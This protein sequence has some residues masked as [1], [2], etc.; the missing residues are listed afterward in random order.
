[1]AEEST[2]LNKQELDIL[3]DNIQ[4]AKDEVRGKFEDIHRRLETLESEINHELDV[5]FDHYER[6]I[7]RR[8]RNISQ[9]DIAR[10]RLYSSLQHND[11]NEALDKLLKAVDS[12]KKTFV[13]EVID[14]PNVLVTWDE[15]YLEETL[16]KL[17]KI[18]ELKYSKEFLKTT[19]LWHQSKR[20]NG[21]DDLNYPRGIAYDVK[22][23]NLYVADCLNDRIQVY[24]EKGNVIDSICKNT[25]KLPR[26]IC[27]TENFLFVTSD[28]HQLNKIN[29]KT[30]EV[31]EKEKFQYLLSGIDSFREKYIYACDLMDLQIIVMRISNLSV[32]RKFT[33]K[34][35]KN[36]DTQTRDI[37]VEATA[38]YVLFHK[39]QFPLQSFTHEG[40][41]IR[42]IVTETMVLDAKYFCLDA[43][44]NF[45][46]I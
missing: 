21:E 43:S 4:N 29:K 41:L 37:R 2:K 35:T 10:S 16:Q 32:K 34:A 12:E 3:R 8:S 31:L 19:S 30:G 45:F 1:M 36:S 26:R 42:H 5:I 24:D 27:I 9:L 14:V 18:N 22:A 17:C 25:V 11:L 46:D 23:H 40:V 20:G 38:I 13:E 15:I 39:S 7:I 33:L 6:L 28:L 44:S